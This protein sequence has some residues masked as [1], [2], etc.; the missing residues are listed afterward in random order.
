MSDDTTTEAPTPAEETKVIVNIESVGPSSDHEE[1]MGRETNDS[2]VI[3]RVPT[4]TLRVER[5]EQLKEE[6]GGSS[7][8]FTYTSEEDGGSHGSDECDQPKFEAPDDELKEK[9]IK[10]VEFY[11]CDVNI[12]KD[13]F[14]LKHVRRNKLGYVS[15]K[16]ITSFK[17]LKSL[18][19]DYRVVAYSLRHSDKLEVNEEGTKVRRVEPLPEYDE[20]T[21]SRTVVAVN[22]PTE[23]P[24]IETVAEI[25][26][27][28]GEVVLIRVLRPGK[29]IPPDV[30]KHSAK[31]PEI[32]TTVCA[33]V[34]FER[35]EHAK[36]ACV[37][38]ND[39]SDWRKGMRIVMLAPPKR[40]N[41]KKNDDKNDKDEISPDEGKDEKKKRRRGGKKKKTRLEEIAGENESSCHSSGSEGEG[42]C[43]PQRLSPKI[44]DLD[45][46]HLSPNHSPRTSPRTTPKTSPLSSPRCQRRGR[47]SH[48]KSPLAEL[49]PGDNRLSPRSSPEMSR[50]RF[51]NSSGGESTPTSPWVQRRLKAAQE[52]QDRSPVGSP[53]L[54]RRNPDGT[55]AMGITPK[56]L[57]ME[58]VYRHPK[59]PDGSHGFYG[60]IG[61]GK[62]RSNTVS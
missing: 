43:K 6:D 13:A 15:L 28:C 41:K 18:T 4:P 36:K 50:K 12:L 49:S 60:G 22:L 53:R 11:F 59:G 30:K 9:I 21:P 38:M 26:S 39:T 54:G 47:G 35:H 40:T 2:E 32:G 29:T 27:K 24:T 8:S 61:R 25:F 45:P 42:P 20:T 1:N 34:E 46:N 7:S 17:K 51:E 33:V 16:L 37:E 57:D 5:I 23:N 31:H 44:K 52:L 58:G 3:V 55:F 62:P 10:Q 48:G 56:M 19:K 14:L